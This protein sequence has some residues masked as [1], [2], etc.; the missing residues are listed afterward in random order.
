MERIRLDVSFME[1]NLA[2]VKQ[3][4]EIAVLPELL[5]RWFSRPP[6]RIALTY[7]DESLSIPSGSTRESSPSPSGGNSDSI[8]PASSNSSVDKYCYCQQGEFGKMVGCD[9]GSCPYKW[10]HL[11]C[12]KL[13]SLPKSSKWYCPGCRKLYQKKKPKS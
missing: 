11:P 9:N 3:F 13:K 1:R 10:F 8:E 5:G 7:S 4:F 12:L 6:E 2:K